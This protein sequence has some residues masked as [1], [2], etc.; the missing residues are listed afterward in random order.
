MKDFHCILKDPHEGMLESIA[1][2]L[3]EK[4]DKT[5]PAV[6]YDSVAARYAIVQTH[7]QMFPEKHV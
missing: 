6:Q 3:W 4:H 7:K 5:G 1:Q 2:E